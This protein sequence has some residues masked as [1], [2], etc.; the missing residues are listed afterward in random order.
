MK[1]YFYKI[2]AADLLGYVMSIPPQKRGKA[3]M[4]FAKRLVAKNSEGDNYTQTIIDEAERFIQQQREHGRKGGQATLKRPSSD[5]ISKPQGNSSNNTINPP[6]VPPKGGI[7]SGKEYSQDFLTF[8]G[9]YPKKTGKDDAWK[10]WQKA[11]PPIADVMNSLHW[12]KKSDQWLKDNG[13][14]IPNPS[15]YIN[16]GRWKDEKP[17]VQE[18]LIY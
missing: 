5:P 9:E 7:V 16:Q 3:F 14:F 18:R 15:T 17:V 13:Q 6:I 1:P 4:D 2:N 12:Q 8:W 11:K 10:A